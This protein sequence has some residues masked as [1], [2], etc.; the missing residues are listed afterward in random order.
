MQSL[1]FHH[2]GNQAQMT[3][4]MSI[5][6]VLLNVVVLSVLDFSPIL[7]LPK[8][9]WSYEHTRKFLFEWVAKLPWFE[10]VFVTYGVFH[11]VK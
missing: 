7:L 1:C 11:D 5:P 10:N 9:K 2:L 3:T 6:H 8:L 4:L